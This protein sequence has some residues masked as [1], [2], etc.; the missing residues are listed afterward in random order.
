MKNSDMPAMPITNH[1][2]ACAIGDGDNKYGGLT[3]REMLAMHVSGHVM[4]SLN[5]GASN[6]EWEYPSFEVLA[7]QTVA[8]AD[9]LLRELDK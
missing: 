4:T 3:K 7:Q 2:L 9:A 6:G 1:E 8:F 5:N